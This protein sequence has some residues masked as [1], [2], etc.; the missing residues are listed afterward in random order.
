M[1]VSVTIC[2]NVWGWFVSAC[3]VCFSGF[4]RFEGDDLRKWRQETFLHERE[5]VLGGYPVHEHL[6]DQNIFVFN[7]K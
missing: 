1:F 3:Y 5:D 6:K 4:A 2:V 7:L